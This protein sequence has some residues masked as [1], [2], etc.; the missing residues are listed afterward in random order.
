[1]TRVKNNNKRR[2]VEGEK[3]KFYVM[4]YENDSRKNKIIFPDSMNYELE[5]L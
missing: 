5:W 4:Y 2:M 3:G 1:M